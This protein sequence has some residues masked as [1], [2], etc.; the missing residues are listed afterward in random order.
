MSMLKLPAVVLPQDDFSRLAQLATKASADQH[1]LAPVL[2]AEL[3]RARVTHDR[4]V[5]S[6]VATL[7]RWLTYRVDWGPTENRLLVHPDD[8]AC[9]DGALSVLSPEGAAIVGI[10]IGDRMPFTGVDGQSHIITLVSVDAGPRVVPFRS[11][12]HA[13]PKTASEEPFDPGPSA[14]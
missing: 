3:K 5:L 6:E 8:P 10:G 13:R 9:P 14:A 11:R 12:A 1:P 4:S 2:A 7:N